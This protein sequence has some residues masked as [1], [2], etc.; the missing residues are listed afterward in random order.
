MLILYPE[1]CQCNSK[2]Q[3]PE[4]EGFVYR[5]LVAAGHILF[6]S[7]ETVRKPGQKRAGCDEIRSYDPWREKYSTVLLEYSA[8]KHTRFSF[9]LISHNRSG[10]PFFALSTRKK[11]YCFLFSASSLSSLNSFLQWNFILVEF[12]SLLHVVLVICIILYHMSLY[13]LSVLYVYFYWKRLNI[14][15]AKTSW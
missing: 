7:D 6:G 3:R 12:F 2:M 15:I 10:S 1:N 5:I 13:L 9:L 4:T 8:L 14:I 11:H